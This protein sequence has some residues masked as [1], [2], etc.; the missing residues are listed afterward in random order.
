MGIMQ[1]WHAVDGLDIEADVTTLSLELG[2][3]AQDD[4][5]LAATQRYSAAGLGTAGWSIG[6]FFRGARD[7]TLYAELGAA[8]AP[9]ITMLNGAA[10]G[11]L[12]YFVQAHTAEYSPFSGSM[13]D[14]LGFTFGGAAGGGKTWRAVMAIP[15]QAMDDVG[16]GASL[17]QTTL[18]AA[19]YVPPSGD[20]PSEWA[21]AVVVTAVEAGVEYSVSLNTDIGGAGNERIATTTI[22]TVGV[23]IFTAAG[24]S[25]DIDFNVTSGF[26]STLGEEITAMV[27]VGI[28]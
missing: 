26:T 27:L 22:D 20:A 18:A 1:G 5:R 10:A 24:V 13:G 12:G 21:L 11:A 19:G 15:L 9:L 17:A 2:N 4:T 7:T 14:N 23:H 8:D 3:E 28:R 25:G 6:G 16:G